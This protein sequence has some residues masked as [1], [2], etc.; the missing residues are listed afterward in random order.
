M[1]VAILNDYPSPERSGST[2]AAW[3]FLFSPMLSTPVVPVPRTA[4]WFG[5]CLF[6]S[7]PFRAPPARRR[8]KLL[9]LSCRSSPPSPTMCCGPYVFHSLLVSRNRALRCLADT[10]V[11]WCPTRPGAARDPAAATL[12]ATTIPPATPTCTPSDQGSQPQQEHAG[13]LSL[14]CYIS[15]YLMA[16]K[17]SGL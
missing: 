1:A 12:Q 11:L 7:P 4:S 17:G 14:Y 2:Q 3:P 5:V 10:S 9:N 8:L 15:F 13:D 16:Y 6:L